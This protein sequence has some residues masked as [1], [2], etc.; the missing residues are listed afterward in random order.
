MPFAPSGAGLRG[1]TAAADG[2]AGAGALGALAEAAGVV[3]YSE[4]IGVTLEDGATA[5]GTAATATTGDGGSL[6][7]ATTGLRFDSVKEALSRSIDTTM[8]RITPFAIVMD[9]VGAR[10]GFPN[11]GAI[12]TVPPLP[13][14]RVNT[15]PIGTVP[16]RGSRRSVGGGRSWDCVSAF[17]KRET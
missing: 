6:A 2:T 3:A 5:E 9:V 12:G 14:G 11:A 1:G 10:A 7:A 13:P 15:G 17:R 4:A 8:R 16:P